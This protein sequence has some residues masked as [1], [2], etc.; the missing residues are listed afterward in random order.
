MFWIYVESKFRSLSTTM[1]KK[2]NHKK[3]IVPSCELAYSKGMFSFPKDESKKRKWLEAI[4][5]DGHGPWD[6]VCFNHFREKYDYCKKANGFFKLA[7]DAIP[8]LRLPTS[9]DTSVR[10]FEYTIKVI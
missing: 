4:K 1:S 3:C 7:Y 9:S 2:S 5:L 10:N 8:S 6:V